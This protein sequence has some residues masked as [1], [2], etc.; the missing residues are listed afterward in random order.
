MVEMQV[1]HKAWTCPT[2]AWTEAPTLFLE[3]V[4]QPGSGHTGK[5]MA[6]RYDDQKLGTSA[7]NKLLCLHA[8]QDAIYTA[9]D[10]NL[11]WDT[12]PSTIAMLSITVL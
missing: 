7:R 11:G 10:Y 5:S 8:L 3:T 4:S 6:Y 1:V 12:I 9:D 2:N